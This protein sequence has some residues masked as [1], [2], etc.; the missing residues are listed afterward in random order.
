MTE[1]RDRAASENMVES[2]AV[3]EPAVATAPRAWA[4]RRGAALALVFVGGAAGTAVR[5]ALTLAV[6][7]PGDI[8]FATWGINVA[9]SLILGVLLGVLMSRGSGF[10]RGLRLLFGTGFCGGFTTYSTLAEQS[11]DL[12]GH[13]LWGAGVVYSLGTLLIGA[14][15]A[16]AG[17]AAGAAVAR[18][19]EVT[20]S[21]GAA[22]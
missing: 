14:I 19:R 16:W 17:I 5:E 10:H 20:E 15:A 22:R 7:Q 1:Q 9:G 13:G 18:S 12:A 11:A 3:T 8:P 4:E 6:P 2:Q 21:A